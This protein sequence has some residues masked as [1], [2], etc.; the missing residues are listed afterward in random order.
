M[1]ILVTGATGFVGRN[2]LPLLKDNGH[3]IIALTR[4]TN[5]AGVGLPIA[6]QIV[7]WDPTTQPPP[8]GFP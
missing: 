4:N 7:H 2:L 1:K 5:T 6:C 3:E 8:S